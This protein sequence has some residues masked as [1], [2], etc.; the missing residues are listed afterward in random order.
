MS[1][2]KAGAPSIVLGS[3]GGA[4]Q[5]FA[6]VHACAFPSHQHAML[7]G[8]VHGSGCGGREV[9][10]GSWWGLGVGGRGVLDA[11][12]AFFCVT[13]LFGALVLGEWVCKLASKCLRHRGEGAQRENPTGLAISV[14]GES[15]WHNSRLM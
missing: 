10:V 7:R 11:K 13:V 2:L 15:R 3:S 12:E 9:G 14:R 6:A 5:S 8:A 1:G 4:A